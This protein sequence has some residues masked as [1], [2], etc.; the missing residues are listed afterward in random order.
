MKNRFIKFLMICILAIG[1]G[2]YVSQ[3]FISSQSGQTAYAKKYKWHTLAYEKHFARKHWKWKNRSKKYASNFGDDC[4]NY[5]SQ[6]ANVGKYRRTSAGGM[7]IKGRSFSNNKWYSYKKKG[8][9]GG[10]IYSSSWTK[11][12]DI[13]SY[14]VLHLGKKSYQSSKQSYIRR[15]AAPGDLLQFWD[16][17]DGWFHSVTIYSKS[18]KDVYYTAHTN[19]FLHKALRNANHGRSK[20]QRIRAYRVVKMGVRKH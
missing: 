3:V 19:S 5:A 12:D 11:V 9:H 1:E 16:R 4:T 7:V 10:R 13:W 15:K 14:F 20:G 6:L 17:N 18:K 2:S 8:A